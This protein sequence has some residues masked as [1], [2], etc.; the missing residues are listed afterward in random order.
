MGCCASTSSAVSG[1]PNSPRSI[2]DRFINDTDKASVS[3]GYAGNQEFKRLSLKEKKATIGLKNLQMTNQFD[4]SYA[5]IKKKEWE[6]I[7]KSFVSYTMAQSLKKKNLAFV[8]LIRMA[9]VSENSNL[10]EV[11]YFQHL[12]IYRYHDIASLYMIHSCFNT[13]SFLFVYPYRT[14]NCPGVPRV[15][16]VF[17]SAN[18]PGDYTVGKG[19]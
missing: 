6:S 19:V 10:I 18:V 14:L 9:N 17:H 15:L 7:H 4:N 3:K 2:F 16:D 12:D 1:R 11:E 13:I 5:V 8:A